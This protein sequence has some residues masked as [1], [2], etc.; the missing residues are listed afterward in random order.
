MK[1]HFTFLALFACLS[2]TTFFSSCEKEN[3][4][5]TNVSIERASLIGK[6]HLTLYGFTNPPTLLYEYQTNYTFLE[7]GEF[8]S[9]SILG[10]NTVYV[11][12]TWD[13]DGNRLLLTSEDNITFTIESFSQSEMVISTEI[14]AST[15]AYYLFE[16]VNTTEPDTTQSAFDGD[17]A[18][19]SLFSVGAS[20]K[21]HFSRGNL[22]YQASSNTWR[23]A[24]NQYD[25]L[26]ENNVNVSP[27]YSGW[28]DL[29][30]WG[31]GNNPTLATTDE[32]D[33]MEF[34]EWGNNTIVNGGNQT[35]MWR[36][37]TSNEW[38]YLISTRANATS[39]YGTA[40]IDGRFKGLVLLPDEWNLPSGVSFAPGFTGSDI[41][42]DYSQNNYTIEEWKKMEEAGA[43]FF[44]AAGVRLGSEIWNVNNYGLYWSSTP[45][46]DLKCRDMWFS[47]AIAW[48]ASDERYLG[49][50]VRLVKEFNN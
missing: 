22:Q 15:I 33:Y 37:L 31:T 50:S 9:E 32:N 27:S 23:F 26:G 39:K 38:Q 7:T 43:L 11:E 41:L 36:T 13:L 28:I 49:F 42:D 24:E 34:H 5:T 8:F 48:P 46:T 44:P 29:F 2:M 12:G 4:G 17:G 1:K 21:V 35:G 3:S 6:W 25:Y 40:T 45:D 14:D 10:S 16:K 47:S 20:K 18:S 30:G 19:K